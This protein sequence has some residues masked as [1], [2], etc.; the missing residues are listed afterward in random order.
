MSLRALFYLTLPVWVALAA[1]LPPS[2]HPGKRASTMLRELGI[3]PG[4]GWRRFE[5]RVFLSLW[6]SLLLL[7]YGFKSSVPRLH[8]FL[9]SRVVERGEISLDEIA[10]M[11]GGVILAAPHYGA[12]IPVCLRVIQLMH[13]RKRFNVIFNDPKVTP[14]NA[15][16][17]ELFARLGC[18]VTVLYPDRRGTIAALKALKRGECLAILPDVYFES[19]TTIAVPFFGRLLRVMA[20]TAFFASRTGAPI[21]PVYGVPRRSMG[22]E[23]LI[24][25]PINSS[26]H[27]AEDEAQTL[28]NITA[29]MM[30]EMER[31]FV[32]APEHWNYWETL[33][34]RSTRLA[35]APAPADEH[36]EH[37]HMLS[38]KLADAPVLFREIPQLA[39]HWDALRRGVATGS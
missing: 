30:A 13:G 23:L 31:Q 35:A 7:G 34:H 38:D 25:Q 12:F 21:V 37:W 29:A 9:R 39:Q 36:A 4:V 22:M 24:G 11:P 15:P 2:M 33:R 5:F 14:S 20:G 1:V 8:R 27:E 32:V 10:D 16:Y 6:R 28:F 26:A 18:D 3:S 19:D 17:G